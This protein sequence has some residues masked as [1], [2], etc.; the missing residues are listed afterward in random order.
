MAAVRGKLKKLQ[1]VRQCAKKEITRAELNELLLGADNK[2][3]TVSHMAVNWGKLETLQ[4]VWEC[5]KEK[6][7]TEKLNKLLL[8]TDSKGRTA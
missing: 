1:K 7:T 2:E 8:G 6:L 4:N 3:R 5:P